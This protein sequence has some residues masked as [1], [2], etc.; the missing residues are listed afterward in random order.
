VRF[1]A[2]LLFPKFRGEN[3]RHQ[4]QVELPINSKIEMSPTIIGNYIQ[5]ASHVLVVL[6]WR[7]LT[8]GETE[9]IALVLG[10]IGEAVGF[11]MTQWNATKNEDLTPLGAYKK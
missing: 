6:G 4:W 1:V 7:A 9:A 3:A 5:L 10:L 2:L 8:P 11:L